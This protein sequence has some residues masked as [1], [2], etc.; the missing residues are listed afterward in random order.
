[1]LK[2]FNELGNIK[3]E[4]LNAILYLPKIIFISIILSSL[5][6]G[7]III[8]LIED[9]ILSMNIPS[10]F[11]KLCTYILYPVYFLIKIK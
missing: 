7:L 3:K 8:L 1:L 10:K 5:I 4:S 11:D 6:I 9:N 2:L